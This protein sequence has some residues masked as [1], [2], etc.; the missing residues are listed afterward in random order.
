MGDKLVD[1]IDTDPTNNKV[2][3]LRIVSSQ[4]ENISNPTTLIKM[5][6]QI[7]CTLSNSSVLYFTS[8]QKCAEL[9][10]VGVGTILKWIKDNSKIA[11]IFPDVKSLEYINYPIPKD[12][13]IDKWNF[14]KSTKYKLSV[15]N[16]KSIDDVN[17]FLIENQIR[18][19]KDLINKGYKNLYWKIKYKK[20]TDKLTYYKDE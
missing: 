20:W 16:F 15:K 1:H 19:Q 4:K 9:L 17:K 11:K 3:N 18:K 2:N 5:S 14:S 12:S 6:K 7:K 8:R 10:D 13:L